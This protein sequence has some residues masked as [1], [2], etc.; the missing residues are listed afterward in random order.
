MNFTKF[1]KDMFSGDP[2]KK[3]DPE[4]KLKFEIMNRIG[5]REISKLTGIL[6]MYN[7][8]E[9]NFFKGA[10]LSK[11][12]E[13][14]RLETFIIFINNFSNFLFQ[15]KF[16]DD[17]EIIAKISTKIKTEDNPAHW[18]LAPILFLKGRN[19]EALIE[20]EAALKTI[21]NLES[22]SQ[23]LPDDYKGEFDINSISFDM[24]RDLLNELIQQIKEKL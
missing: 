9:Q 1:F 2:W 20:A 4:L 3:F 11:L 8:F 18:T 17:A 12:P 6:E 13:G 14:N 15:N 16:L 7:A 21:D 10:F 24:Q 19:E 5:V 22:Q 23:L